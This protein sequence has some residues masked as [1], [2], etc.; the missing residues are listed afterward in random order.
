MTSPPDERKV[1]CDLCGSATHPQSD[2]DRKF[3]G[4]QHERP[5]RK[6]LCQLQKGHKGSH[7]AVIYWEDE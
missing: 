2:H 6:T 1:F 5:T 7:Q 4:C 3:I